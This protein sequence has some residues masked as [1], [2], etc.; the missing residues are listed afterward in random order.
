MNK[1]EQIKKRRQQAHHARSVDS[2]VTALYASISGS[3]GSP[4]DWQKLRTLF[5]PGARLL[6]TVVTP[7][8]KVTLSAMTVD[9]FIGFAEPYFRQHDFYE[10]E[11]ARR[12][13]QFGHIVHVWSTYGAYPSLDS[14][15]PSA[16]GINSIQLWFDGS[17]WWVMSM[18]WDDE[19]PDNPLPREYLRQTTCGRSS[20]R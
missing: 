4:R 10:R 13:E 19:R 18:L 12:T 20:V 9:E 11:L 2:A 15:S 5:Y 16:Q 14:L 7:D 17:R 8:G 1:I 6:R 3:A